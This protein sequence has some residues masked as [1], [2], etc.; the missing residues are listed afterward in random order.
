MK[1]KKFNTAKE[2]E[3]LF[4]NL[5]DKETLLVLH[6]RCEEENG[7]V[8]VGYTDKRSVISAIAAIMTVS[9]ANK[10]ASKGFDELTDIIIEAVRLV[11]NS[12]LV[13]LELIHREFKD[14]I[15]D[16]K[17]TDDADTE[18]EEEHPCEGCEDI[19]TCMDDDAI[20][21]RKKHHLPKPK[22]GKKSK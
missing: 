6:D 17:G 7:G 22:K 10:G 13:G 8:S 21:Y 15:E 5:G 19:L 14:A 16:W 1:E 18:E 20:D 3:R 9:L 4:D 12:P 11:R 2:I